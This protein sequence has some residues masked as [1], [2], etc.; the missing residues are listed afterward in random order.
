M[1]ERVHVRYAAQVGRQAGRI[2]MGESYDDDVCMYK[3]QRLCGFI[4]IELALWTDGAA[5]RGHD[6][7]AAAAEAQQS[8]PGERKWLPPLPSPLMSRVMEYVIHSNR[9]LTNAK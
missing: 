8:E 1:C 4:E 3:L 5:T 7:C 6:D 2:K 9:R